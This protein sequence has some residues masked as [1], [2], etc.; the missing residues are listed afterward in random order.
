M[1]KQQVLFFR[2]LFLRAFV[3][4]VIFAVLYFIITISFWD[5]WVSLLQKMFKLDEKDTS[6]AVIEGF[7]LI[8]L[9]L[10]FFMLVP[11]IA[12]HWTSKL[13]R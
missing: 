9:I 4:G 13:K 8:R 10:V 3:V 6:R 12:L 7:T 2:N 1:E 11:A 5:T